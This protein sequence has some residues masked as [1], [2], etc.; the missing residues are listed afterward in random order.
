[1]LYLVWIHIVL[2]LIPVSVSPLLNNELPIFSWIRKT[3][4][5]RMWPDY[6]LLLL[7][8]ALSWHRVNLPHFL[9]SRRLMS[10]FIC[11][12]LFRWETME[13]WSVLTPLLNNYKSIK[14][15]FGHR[16]IRGHT[17]PI[18]KEIAPFFSIRTTRNGDIFLRY[19]L[20]SLDRELLSSHGLTLVG[21]NWKGFLNLLPCALLLS[22]LTVDGGCLVCLWTIS[23]CGQISGSHTATATDRIL[24]FQSLLDRICYASLFSSIQI[25]GMSR[26]L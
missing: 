26:H 24:I 15:F 2:N 6:I 5:H 12:C 9:A 23:D 8:L 3:I 1:M 17:L 7:D 25:W 18:W 21:R 22:V 19:E 13:W 20:S 10:I 14:L 16:W 11:L 4:N